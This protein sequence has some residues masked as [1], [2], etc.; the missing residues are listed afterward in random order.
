M[1]DAT[2]IDEAASVFISPRCRVENFFRMKDSAGDAGVGVVGRDS[3]CGR[4]MR[5]DS[6][7]K[8]TDKR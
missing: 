4:T 8:Q 5:Q 6:R 7:N 3:P 2:A 1:D